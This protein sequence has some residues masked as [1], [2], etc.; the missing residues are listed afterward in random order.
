[1]SVIWP[2]QAR[3]TALSF[4]LNAFGNVVNDKSMSP[5]VRVLF[6]RWLRC[7]WICDRASYGSVFWR[8]RTQPR[9][10]GLPAADP[11]KRTL[12]FENKDSSIGVLQ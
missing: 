4:P 7:Q 11:D 1:M 12:T 5:K 6:P 3:G 2:C 8:M 10:V 9:K